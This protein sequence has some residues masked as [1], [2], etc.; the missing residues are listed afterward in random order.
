MKVRDIDRWESCRLIDRRTELP[1]S[2]GVY[3][4][5]NAN[6]VMYIGKSINLHRRWSSG[7]HRYQQ[8]AKLK[9]PRIA[10]LRASEGQ[11]DNIERYFIKQYNPAWNGSKVQ[12]TPAWFTVWK[13][14]LIAFAVAAIAGAVI[15]LLTLPDNPPETTPSNIQQL[16]R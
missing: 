15:G 16:N 9:H 11:I 13:P 6:R 2:S 7:H 4:V 10:W 8:T 3:A 5:I 1:K 14:R 12:K